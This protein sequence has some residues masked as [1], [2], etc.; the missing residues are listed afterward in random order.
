[1]NTLKEKF[2][3]EVKIQ[4]TKEFGYSNKM[5]VPTI[6][7]VSVNAGLSRA[8]SNPNFAEEVFADLKLITGQAPVRAKAKKS[9]AGFKIRQ[10]QTVGMNV[11]LRNKK[12]WDFVQ[13]LVCVSIPRIKDF[14]G[15]DQK[16]FDK[17][18][19][20]N[21]GFKEQ[22]IFPEISPDDINTVFG[23][24][25]TITTTAK[26]KEEGVRMF[27]LLGFPIKDNESK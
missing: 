22:M 6:S 23:L 17:N 14:Q 11:T 20:L 15:I 3:K 2:N 19:N 4:M 1:M 24:Q 8:I 13:K 26:T 12:A 5:A 7:K 10:G 25:V 16:N 21:L 9:I 18:G 27:K